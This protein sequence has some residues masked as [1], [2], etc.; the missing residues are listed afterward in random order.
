LGSYARGCS[1]R[2]VSALS[3][4]CSGRTRRGTE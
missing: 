2:D 1:A 4:E 3:R